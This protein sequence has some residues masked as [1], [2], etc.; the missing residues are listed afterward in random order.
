[1]LPP[2]VD[3]VISFITMAISEVQAIVQHNL[4]SVNLLVLALTAAG[5]PGII[6]NG[7]KEN[8]WEARPEI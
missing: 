2:P 7:S 3:Q 6:Y 8:G 5:A 1:M 4:M